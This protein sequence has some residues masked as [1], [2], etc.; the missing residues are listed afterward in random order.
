[1]HHLPPHTRGASAPTEA[2]D[3]APL[4]DPLL[5]LLLEKAIN[6]DPDLERMLVRMRRRLLLA[7]AEG[8]F[9]RLLEETGPEFLAAL[10]QQCFLNEYV[11]YESSHERARIDELTD[12]VHGQLN[13]DR[14]LASRHLTL[15]A[16][17]RPLAQ[18]PFAA[19][20][21]RYYE[22]E[23]QNFLYKVIRLQLLG[24]LHEKSLS[25]DITAVTHITEPT[26]VAVQAQYERHPYPRWHSMDLHRALPVAEYLNQLFPHLSA[27]PQHWAQAPRVLV[28]GCGTGKQAIS[29][30]MRFANSEV[31]A[32]DLSRAS[33]AFGQRMSRELN[34]NNVSFVQGDILALTPDLW[35]SGEHFD[36]IECVG[37][38]HHLA[39]PLDGWQQLMRVLKPGGLLRIG[40]YSRQAR[41]RLI[42]A[43]EL[44]VAQQ[45]PA[46]LD[47]IRA[48]RRHV[49]NLP[50]GHPLCWLFQAADFFSTSE[51][52]DLLFHVN[53]HE[54][55][56][57]QI[58]AALAKFKLK[59]M[60]FE[61]ANEQVLQVYRRAFA[62][63]PDGVDLA[64]WHQLE[65]RYPELFT[66]MYQ[67]WA[68][69]Q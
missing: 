10:A 45:W 26:S 5:I 57:M 36:I 1:M 48:L 8:T 53:E 43:R 56:L 33:L 17:Y 54:F 29:A 15:L 32:L 13:Q 23:N 38:L 4:R 6:T 41:Q 44:A 39:D 11:W 62:Q 60:G 16:C 9:A 35:P 42:P 34:V 58:H 7:V 3:L 24:P 12:F 47:G 27:Q 2:E 63:D 61:L 52:R 59:F 28:A 30:A 14:R 49:L 66:G 68:Q 31:L 22:P 19:Q 37:V 64:G 20:I 67:F 18:L 25:N 46:D 21:L 65:A 50:T 69:R 40:L 51:C 55:D